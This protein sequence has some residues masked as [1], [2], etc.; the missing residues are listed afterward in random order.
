MLCIAIK[1]LH[2]EYSLS[3][4]FITN[5]IQ[6]ILLHKI[7]VN[8]SDYKETEYHKCHATFKKAD[9]NRGNADFSSILFP[10]VRLEPCQ[11]LN[12]VLFQQFSDS[13][14]TYYY[15]KFLKFYEL[16]HTLRKLLEKYMQSSSSKNV[17]K[18]S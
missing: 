13:C 6:N 18:T 5:F 4:H 8:T 1:K 9:Q 15:F 17:T 11:P 3:N 2:T 10:E 14:V 16:V 7:V 12:L